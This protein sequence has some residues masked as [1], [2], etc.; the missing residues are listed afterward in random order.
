[1]QQI[2]NSANLDK[3]FG[4]LLES[5]QINVV[6]QGAAAQTDKYNSTVLPEQ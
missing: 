4:R 2:W 6:R 3:A 5:M 1:M